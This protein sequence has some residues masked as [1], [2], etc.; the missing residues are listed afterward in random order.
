MSGERP[1]LSKGE[2]E[3]ARCVWELKQATVREVHEL[4]STQR[5]IDFST[6]QTYLRRLADKGYLKSGKR[7]RTLVYSPRVRAGTVI[8]ETIDDL[9]DRLFSGDTMPLFRHLIETR[10]ISEDEIQQLRDMLDQR[11]S[12]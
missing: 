6:V 9:V 10:K 12:E 4:L 11:D 8:R 2:M 7:G 1:A 3:V 5:D